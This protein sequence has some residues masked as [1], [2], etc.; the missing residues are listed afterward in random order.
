MKHIRRSAIVEHSAPDLYAL[1]EHI[2][3]YPEFLPWC[4][5]ARVLERAPG[6]T[7][8]T[9]QIGM[10]GAR[11]SLSTDNRNRAGEAIEM[12]LV[13]GPFRH[14]SAGWKFTPL[15]QHAAK[16]EFSMAYE[17]GNA[18]LARVL[19][20]LFQ[21]IADTMVNAFTRRAQAVY[22]DARGSGR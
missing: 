15:G 3:A 2:E 10:K 12:R 11:H 8:A 18:A 22:G 13:E 7:R 14:F 1:V 6:R 4:V 16:I 20:P 17:F 9:L 19:Q 5:S 21:H